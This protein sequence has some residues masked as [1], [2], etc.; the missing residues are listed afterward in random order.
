MHVS[1]MP[2][3]CTIGGMDTG[4][5]I[6]VFMLPKRSHV[7]IGALGNCTFQAGVYMYVGSAQRNLMARIERHGRRNK[8]LRWHIDYLSAKARMLGAILVPGSRRQE[9]SLA[10]KV[11]ALHPRIVPG[12]GSSDCGCEGHLFYAGPSFDCV[13]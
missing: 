12:F 4:L 8:P 6:A 5:Y 2:T 7:R 3:R 13:E 9:C 11:A 10:R 1:V